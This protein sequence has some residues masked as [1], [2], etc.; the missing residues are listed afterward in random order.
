MRELALVTAAA[1]H[2]YEPYTYALAGPLGCGKGTDIG[3]ALCAEALFIEAGAPG[4]LGDTSL[5]LQRNSHV[6]IKTV[7]GLADNLEKLV[8][9][10]EGAGR[11]HIER[12]GALVITDATLAIEDSVVEWRRDRTQKNT[13][14][15]FNQRDL[16]VKIMRGIARHYGV[17]A[18][19]IFHTRLPKIENGI[20]VEEGRLSV[21][22]NKMEASNDISASCDCLWVYDDY[23]EGPDPWWSKRYYCNPGDPMFR[24][25]DRND[26][27]GTI[28]RYAPANFR[29]YIFKASGVRLARPAGLEWQ[30]DLAERVANALE[31]EGVRILD[32]IRGAHGFAAGR[33]GHHVR[34]AIQDGIARHGYRHLRGL[35]DLD[36]LPPRGG[37]ATT[38]PPT[39]APPAG[40]SPPAGQQS[41]APSPPATPQ[42]P[43]NP[44]VPPPQDNKP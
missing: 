20:V 5:P 41:A 44:A 15:A 7:H 18:V 14:Y 36:D 22:V 19:T 27:L 29:E 30:D 32:V 21:G 26:V 9:W 12:A 10:C 17:L 28:N 39:G 38:A 23:P 16:M 24:G 31:A 33:D 37:K 3:R 34:W 2:G 43:S 4:Q 25:K 13:Y 11:E 35:F 8:G 1:S 40:G 42:V 6:G